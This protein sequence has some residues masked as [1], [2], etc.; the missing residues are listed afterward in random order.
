MKVV[1]TADLKTAREFRAPERMSPSLEK[2]YLRTVERFSA[3]PA[4]AAEVRSRIVPKLSTRVIVN[5][6]EFAHIE[7]MPPAYRQ[8]YAETL[9]K[10]LPIQSA[11]YTVAKFE[12][13][14]TITRTVVLGLVALAAVTAVVYLALHGYY[15]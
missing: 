15:R 10:A 13:R 1:L 7:E 3:E 11:I 5:G 6:R 14:N 12:H 9:A 8:F 4:A 2:V